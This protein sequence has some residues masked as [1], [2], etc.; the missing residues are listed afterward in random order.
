MMM[1]MIVDDDSGRCDDDDDEVGDYPSHQYRHPIL[2][3]NFTLYMYTSMDKSK[4]F[5]IY[6][7]P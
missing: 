6:F 1:M 2:W 3:L 4:L 5:E 7:T